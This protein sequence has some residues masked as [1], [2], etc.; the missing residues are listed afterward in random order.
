[1][2]RALGQS[3]VVV[4]RP[5][6]NMIIGAEAVARARRWSHRAHRGTRDNG[7]TALES[8]V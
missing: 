4:N 8:A 3:V 5:G 1:M 2:R 7:C 6:V